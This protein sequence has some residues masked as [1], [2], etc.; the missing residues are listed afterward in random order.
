MSRVIHGEAKPASPEYRVWLSMRT[1]C[2]NAR[3]A[4]YKDYGG[5]GI[6][7]CDRWEQYATFLADMGRRPSRQHSL[8]R[9]QNDEGYTPENCR[10]ATP[11]EQRRNTRNLK[12]YTVGGESLLLTDWARR[13]GVRVQV[14]YDRIYKLRWSVE[15]AV[16]TPRREE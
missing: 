6:G 10:W 5:R 12:L 14:V 11:V 7:I 1:R 16:S 4:R 9:K 13:L 2:T 3:R 8:D 15:R